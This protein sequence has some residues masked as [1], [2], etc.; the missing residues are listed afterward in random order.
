MLTEEIKTPNN[1]LIKFFLNL[2]MRDGAEMMLEV[3]RAID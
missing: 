3:E 2:E 1:F